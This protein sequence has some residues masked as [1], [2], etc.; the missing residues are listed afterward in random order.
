MDVPFF[1]PIYTDKKNFLFLNKTTHFFNFGQKAYKVELIDDKFIGREVENRSSWKSIIF[2]ILLC[3]TLIIP[4]LALLGMAIY[5]LNNSF[6]IKQNVCFSDLEP[7]LKREIFEWAGYDMA[8]IAATNRE[9]LAIINNSRSLS[10]KRVASI[11][12]NQAYSAFNFLLE[13]SPNK[14]ELEVSALFVEYIDAIAPYSSPLKIFQE[15]RRALD[16][17][18]DD[19]AINDR[20]RLSAFMA[21]FDLEE[22]SKEGEKCISHLSSILFIKSHEQTLKLDIDKIF[23]LIGLSSQIASFNPRLALI[24]VEIVFDV[25]KKQIAFTGFGLLSIAITMV[26]R[27]NLERAIK[28]VNLLDVAVQIDILTEISKLFY[29]IENLEKAL[30]IAEVALRLLTLN[31]NLAHINTLTTNLA[32]I[33]YK[34]NPEKGNGAAYLI[35]NPDERNRYREF[36][37]QFD[38]F[39]NPDSSLERLETA[40]SKNETVVTSVM[41]AKIFARIFIQDPIK[42]LERFKIMQATDYDETYCPFRTDLFIHELIRIDPEKGFDLLEHIQFLNV[43]LDA[44]AKLAKIFSKTNPKKA[45]KAFAWLEKSKIDLHLADDWE[46]CLPASQYIQ[47]AKALVVS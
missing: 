31:P 36:R 44:A 18:R 1:S 38:V 32:K 37:D 35:D 42:G 34:I 33:L 16:F 22:A 15:A 43:K 14:T 17:L 6:S 45:L 7:N 10:M 39:K 46:I 47:M 23:E 41:K 30:E 21:S 4:I 2:R 27:F 20:A 9:N 11:G 3:L 8:V 5:R 26:A 29:Q 25:L 40:F 28:E 19:N 24:G 12:L 13:K